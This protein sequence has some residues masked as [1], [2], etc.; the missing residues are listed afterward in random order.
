VVPVIWLLVLLV[1]VVLVA[2]AF[3]QYESPP[4]ADD[5][6]VEADLYA[7]RRRLDVVQF[8]HEVRRDALRM[9]RELE[10][11]LNG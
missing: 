3:A 4:D 6:R 11:E 1:V 5:Y 8:K 9:K 7:I 2:A 10:K